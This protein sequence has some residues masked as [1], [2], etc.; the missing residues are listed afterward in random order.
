MKAA[1]YAAEAAEKR[2][3]LERRTTWKPGERE[4]LAR[5]VRVLEDL[6]R[7]AGDQG[8]DDYAAR[9]LAHG[10]TCPPP[11]FIHSAKPPELY[12]DLA[13]R[14]PAPRLDVFAR[15][16]H[17]GWDG[18]GDEYEGESISWPDAA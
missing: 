5:E 15:R 8:Y 10:A 11:R 6:A 3:R 7:C 14:T 13:A 12:D 9:C 2:A 18:W 17:Q 16:Q 4:A 1:A